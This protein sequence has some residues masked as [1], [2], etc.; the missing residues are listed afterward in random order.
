M[1]LRAARFADARRQ[2]P[3]VL[4]HLYFNTARKGPLPDCTVAALT[5]FNEEMRQ[6]GGNEKAWLN[7]VEQARA[8][9]ASLLHC[10]TGEVAFCKNTSEGLN[11]A[12]NCFPWKA[13]DNVVIP[14]GEHS[15]NVYPWLGLASYGVDV[16]IVPLAKPWADAGALAPYIDHHTRAVALSHVTFRPGQR[17]DL[18][19][20]ASHCDSYG[21]YLIVDAVQS[22]GILDVNVRRL[23]ISMLAAGCHKGLLAPH[24]LGI[25][26]CRKDLIEAT[27]P[28]YVARSSMSIRTS[29]GGSPSVTKFELWPDARRF[30]YG[31]PNYSGIR[32]LNASL[33][34]LLSL[35]LTDIEAYVMELGRYLDQKMVERDLVCLAPTTAERHASIH[36]FELPGDGWEA[37]LRDRDVVVSFFGNTVRISLHFFNSREDIDQLVAVI[38]A[39]ILR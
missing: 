22:V 32:A 11:I 14:A 4:S 13:G 24:G 5:R 19:D 15:N 16:R 39:K 2:F 37:H 7:E 36:V 1:S 12:A 18:A 3:A 29:A 26:Y 33:E 34:L 23:G 9:V 30:E 35:E 10:E 21:A 17:N 6:V 20:I 28:R 31:N 38:D 8:K 27:L 25:L